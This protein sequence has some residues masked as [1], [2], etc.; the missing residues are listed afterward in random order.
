MP[1]LDELDD[2]NVRIAVVSQSFSV[3]FASDPNGANIT[4]ERV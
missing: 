1:E 2:E 4:F 3:S